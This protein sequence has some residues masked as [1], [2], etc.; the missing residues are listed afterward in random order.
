MHAG[1]RNGIATA[2][3]T[4]S[5]KTVSLQVL[6][7]TR[8]AERSISGGGGGQ[9]HHGTFLEHSLGFTFRAVPYDTVRTRIIPRYHTVPHRSGNRTV[10]AEAREG[11]QR[12]VNIVII[13]FLVSSGSLVS[14][15]GKRGGPPGTRHLERLWSQWSQ[16]HQWRQSS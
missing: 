8:D 2:A 12:P 11:A 5:T 13:A 14:S 16:W 7:H 6:H 4:I 3:T 10:N 15:R 9:L 1:I